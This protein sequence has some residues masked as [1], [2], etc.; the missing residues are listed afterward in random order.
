VAEPAT[1]LNVIVAE[2]LEEIL[3]K[4]EKNLAD[5][6]SP[7]LEQLA[8]AARPALVPVIKRSKAIRYA[9]D[10]YSEE[11]KKEAAERG[12]FNTPKC[13]EA[14]D[15][16]LQP[17]TF[18]AY[19]GVLSREELHCRHLVHM[20]TTAS[21]AA[22]EVN[23]LLELFQTMVLPGVVKYQV[24]LAETVSAVK[25]LEGATG[26]LEKLLLQVSKLLEEAS[27]CAD[28]VREQQ[29]TADAH[30]EASQKAKAY[31]QKVLPECE[32][33]RAIVDQLE[34]LTSDEFW[35]L[36]KYRELLFFV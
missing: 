22:I 26:G 32:A 21:I 30:E 1:V 19:K 36:P 18:A 7:T 13:A 23:L 3:Q 11:W 6:K 14:F 5:V 33:L 16:Y 2:S 28:K 4:I 34:Q 29:A 12:L 10:N 31:C 17:Q 15:A 35:P 25:S 24:E 9:G 27:L 8:N 20:E